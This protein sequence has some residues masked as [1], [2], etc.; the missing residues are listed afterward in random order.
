[1][2]QQL[3]QDFD[4]APAKKSRIVPYGCVAEL[5][6]SPDYTAKRTCFAGRHMAARG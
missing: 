4:A 5:Y 6:T 2:L 1:L 3:Q